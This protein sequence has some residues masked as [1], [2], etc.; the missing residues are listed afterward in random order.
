MRKI[1]LL[2]VVVLLSIMALA[3]NKVLTGRVTDD[4]GDP[5]PFATVKISGTQT[6]VAADDNGFFRISAP[7][8]AVLEVSASGF[9]TRTFATTGQGTSLTISLTKSDVE[10]AAV[11]VTTS[12]GIKRQAK[13][14]GYAATSL[15]SRTIVQG[16]AVNVQQAL[17]GKVSGVS[18]ATVNSGV[19]ENA[20]VNIRGIRSLTGNNQPM[21]VVDGADR[22]SV[23]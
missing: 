23:V 7:E 6:G 4:Q 19:F 16:K 3:Q 10:L 12:L 17:N 18:V 8:N 20:K 2:L 13:E 21:L 14:L 11:I 15:N 9:V 22:K 1:S 5:V